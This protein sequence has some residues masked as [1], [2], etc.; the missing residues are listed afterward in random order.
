MTPIPVIGVVPAVKPAAA[1]SENRRIGLLATPATVR[2]PYLAD[3]IDEFASDCTVERLGHPNR[4]CPWHCNH[5]GTW[6]WT[7]WFWAALI[8]R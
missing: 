2:R 7:L 4:P 6:V 8:T 1:V 5:S 3:L